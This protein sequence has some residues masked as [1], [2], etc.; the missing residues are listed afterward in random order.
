MKLISNLAFHHTS[1]KQSSLSERDF[2]RS[3]AKLIPEIRKCVLACHNCHGEIHAELH[4]KIIP[5]KL[6]EVQMAIDKLEQEIKY[7][8]APTLGP[9]CLVCGTPCKATYN[10]YC[11][12]TCCYKGQQKIN[13]PLDE[14]FLKMIKSMSQRKVAGLLGVSDQA[15]A[16]HLKRI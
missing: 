4:D 13:W 8:S 9:P 16:K 11:S 6:I 2:Q 10:K 1:N 15:V 7:E 14:E 12:T 5:Q 3:W